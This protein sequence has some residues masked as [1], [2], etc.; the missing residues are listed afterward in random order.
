MPF[1]SIW[2]LTFLINVFY[3]TKTKTAWIYC[4]RISPQATSSFKQDSLKG[5]R[6][7]SQVPQ[8]PIVKGGPSD[9]TVDVSG[10]QLPDS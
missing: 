4:Y 10:G 9:Q 1:S 5:M 2:K 6:T 7:E 3:D 8:A